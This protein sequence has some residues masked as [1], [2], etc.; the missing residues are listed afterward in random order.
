MATNYRIRYAILPAGVGPDDYE[1]EDLEHRTE[2]F[3]LDDPVPDGP[4]GSGLEVR[5]G[6]PVPA[7]QKAIRDHLGDDGREPIVLEIMLDT[8]VTDDQSA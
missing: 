4:V 1:S 7:I 2:V 8:D 3:R 5:Y 6:Q